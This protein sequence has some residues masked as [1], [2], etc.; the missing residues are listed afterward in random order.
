MSCH[1]NGQTPGSDK[2]VASAIGHPLRSKAS[3]E[4]LAQFCEE[5]KNAYLVLLTT[6]SEEK[7]GSPLSDW[8]SVYRMGRTETGW[9][10]WHNQ[11]DGKFEFEFERIESMRG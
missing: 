7:I 5:M 6:G 2:N 9:E 3:M 1:E 4:R 11:R 10:V 8:S